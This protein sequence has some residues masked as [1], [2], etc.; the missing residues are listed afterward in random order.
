LTGK[1]LKA[2]GG[3]FHTETALGVVICRA[4]GSLRLGS[5]SPCAGDF[6]RLGQVGGDTLIEEILPRKN[7]L[8]R[9]PA[10]NIDLLVLVVSVC[11]PRPN[12]VV[13]DTMTVLAQLREIPAAI[14]F[15]KCDLA[16]PEPWA[17][18]YRR[19]GFPLYC[20]SRAEPNKTDDLTTL[21]SELAGKTVLFAGN[22]GAGKSTLL[23][24]ILPGLEQQTA[25]ISRKLGRGK[26]TT[27]QTEFFRADDMLL[28]DTP[29]F[30][31]LDLTQQGVT[32]RE[33]PDG[34]REFAPYFG[35]CRFQ[36]CA[37]L[38]EPDCAVRA[39][40]ETGEIPTERYRNYQRFCEELSGY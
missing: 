27:R 15:T 17:G 33:L 35:Q 13:L 38:R 26:H 28:G 19:A 39:A 14:A 25:E 36:D 34:F 3:S 30:S 40:A 5:I 24:R 11:E 2:A 21:R 29:G 22:S 16:E 9:P 23:N 20:L 7:Y 10:A 37:H 31:A 4:R 12:T 8:P 1:I 6:V 18:I 32:K